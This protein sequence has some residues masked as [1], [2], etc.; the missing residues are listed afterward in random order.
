M[1][2]DELSGTPSESPAGSDRHSSLSSSMGDTNAYRRVTAAEAIA[3]V[4]AA[5]LVGQRAAAQGKTAYAVKVLDKMH[6]IREKKARYVNIEKEALS[7][8]VRLKGVVTL[9]WTFQD[10]HHLCMFFC[11]FL[12]FVFCGKGRR[13]VTD[14]DT[15]GNRLRA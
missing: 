14:T 8:C 6:I 7:R 1:A 11:L 5:A 10:R 15:M 13:S 12:C 9:Y 3:G 2:W 4:P